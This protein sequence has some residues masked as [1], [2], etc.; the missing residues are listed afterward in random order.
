[1]VFF[2][3]NVHMNTNMKII[4]LVLPILIAASNAAG[5]G[6]RQGGF[7][8][9]TAD[10]APAGWT[11]LTGLDK[12]RYGPPDLKFTFDAVRPT[13][14]TDGL[15]GSR[16]L[17]FPASGT[18]PCPVFNHSNG[19]GRGLDGRS[20]AKAAVY[21]TVNLK[22]GR[23][24]FSAWLRTAAGSLY[25][26]GFSLGVSMGPAGDYADDAS[27]G[28]NWT[29]NLATRNSE[30]RGVRER[31]EWTRYHT[32]TFTVKEAG[33]V[34]VWIR[35]NYTNENQ[36]RARWQVDNAAIESLD[37]AT[38]KPVEAPHPPCR[39]RP[40]TFRVRVVP[41]DLESGLVN[42]GQS[43]LIDAAHYRL[44]RQ[45][46]QIPPGTS[47]IYRLPRPD[48][49]GTAHLLAAMAGKAT[50]TVGDTMF[51]IDA[52]DTDKP[53]TREWPLPVPAGNQPL[54]MTIQAT[55]PRPARLFE[56]DLGGIAR[57]DRRLAHVEW[58]T[59]ATVWRI[60]SWDAS[61]QEFGGDE[62]TVQLPAEID[63][64][65]LTPT[66]KWLV[67]FVHHPRSGHRYYLIHGLLTG[68]GEIDIGNDGLVEWIA[69]TKGEE[70]VNFD[71]TDLLKPG[72]NTV[73]F[74]TAGQHDFAAMIEVCPGSTR[75][76]HLRLSFEGD[77]QA[78]LFTRV[79]DNTWFWLRELH[80]EPSG[81]IDASVPRGHWYSQYWP[82]D[83][84]FALREWVHWGYH[85][86]S[87]RCAE[88]ISNRGW[89]G[90]ESNRSGGADN[91]GG[92]IAALQLCEILRRMD[93]APAADSP[94]W[95]R[96][97]NHAEEILKNAAQSPYG[98][99]RGTNWENAGNREHG[100]CYA[101]STTLGAAASLRKAAGLAEQ[102]GHSDQAARWADAAGRLRQ[103]VLQHLVLGEDHRCP[104]GFVLP[105]GTWAY[106][107]RTD[108]TI[109]DQP[110]AG[111]FW[112]AGDF[113]DVDGFVVSDRDLLEVYDRTLQVAIPLFQRTDSGT[114]SGYAVSYD[115][116]DASLVLAALCDRIDY[117][118][119]LLNC[120]ARETDA[121]RDLG[122]EK[123]ELSR[124]AYGSSGH[125]EDTNLVCA[126]GFLWGLRALVG[127][128]DLLADGRQIR[129]VPRMPWHWNAID[130][131]D[132]PVRYR[133]ADGSAAWNRLSFRLE[134]EAGHATLRLSTTEAI[135]RLEARIGPFP[136]DTGPFEARLDG[137]PISMR[138]EVAGDARWVWVTLDAHRE[139]SVLTVR[140][141][142]GQ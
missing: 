17:A 70:I 76:E 61:A 22:P 126:A 119:P 141:H 57:T 23:Y 34:T 27:T 102:F 74:T 108:G 75:R 95:T 99:V 137:K 43:E 45:A 86:D 9:Y 138:A 21:Q 69:E 64:A 132:W 114:V 67:R 16:C 127:I 39:R 94:I 38:G 51:A 81:F 54:E 100:P 80:Y 118:K 116:P 133:R 52:P 6:L 122:T 60:G 135:P 73:A 139:G 128:D 142:T 26:A 140:E 72:E 115:G 65:E 4:S 42:A 29:P 71:A 106:G 78:D 13:M 104:S 131:N 101:L 129:L 40:D 48:Q 32:D 77:D 50:I 41:G 53:T 68:K 1:M 5:D 35:F 15:N 111:Y 109:E 58:D 134:R 90:H 37:D 123:A 107:L 49:S 121:S 14:G 98:L 85:E 82:V 110:L 113:L 96:I 19:D 112:A 105:K 83:I 25:S 88:L 3:Q 87:V 28:I 91:T 7:E 62:S 84:A 36:M 30:R 66:G 31:G 11:V 47:I 89:H 10:G 20:K 125:I 92:N 136:K 12:A 33:P 8:T 97:R 130:V 63:P 18:W 44:F 2:C 93:D 46:R 79:I 59:L 56:I 55:G 24:Q 117:F 120:L 103:A 124:W